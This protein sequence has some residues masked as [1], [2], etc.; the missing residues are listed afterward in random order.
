[1]VKHDLK[2]NEYS[3]GFFW[4]KHIAIQNAHVRENQQ[5]LDNMS[6]IN[7]VQNHIVNL[8]DFVDPEWASP[9][10]SVEISFKVKCIQSRSVFFY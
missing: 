8:W 2:E 10:A 7:N 1:M 9:E 3:S 6:W 4:N 5:Y